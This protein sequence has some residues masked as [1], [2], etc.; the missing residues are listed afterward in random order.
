[1]GLRQNPPG[2]GELS[3][4]LD[5]LGFKLVGALARIFGSLAA[6]DEETYWYGIR[7]G[8]GNGFVDLTAVIGN[9]DQATIDITQDADFVGTRIIHAA[10][11][12]ATGVIQ[13]LQ[14]ATGPSYTMSIRDAGSDRQLTNFELHAETMNGT[15]Q[16]SVPFTKNRLFRRNSTIQFTFTQLQAVAS[17]IFVVMQGYKIYD[18]KALDLIRRR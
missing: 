10:V 11:A 9:T 7:S 18:Q 14:T 2:E 17:R 12:T 13:P 1:M 15:S 5:R 16:R 3:L 8:D 6:Q 4:G